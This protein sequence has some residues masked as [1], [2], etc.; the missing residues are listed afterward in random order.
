MDVT[1]TL[2]AN[3]CHFRATA[4]CPIYDD[5]PC[6]PLSELPK[7]FNIPVLVPEGA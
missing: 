1:T 2:S 3:R 4:V 6:A 5:E 7:N